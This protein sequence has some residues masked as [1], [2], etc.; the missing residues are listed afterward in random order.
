M[1]GPTRLLQVKI[2][3]P[4]AKKLKIHVARRESTLS[5]FVISAI[6]KQLKA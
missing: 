6:L 5:A 2:P 3:A 1:K 4:L